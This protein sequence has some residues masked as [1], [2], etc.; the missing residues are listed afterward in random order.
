MSRAPSPSPSN[1][2]SAFE[3]GDLGMFEEPPGFRPPSP[4]PTFTHFDRPQGPPPARLELRLPPKHSLWGHWLW[5][6]GRV[7]ADYIDAH[8]ALVKGKAVCELGAGSAL[9]SLV[10]MANGAR[11]AAITDYPERVLLQN[12][13]YNV[14]ENFPGALEENRA[15]VVVGCWLP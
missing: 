10:A 8:P 12:I 6:A 3:E 4:E 11:I 14:R 15:A 13:E 2:S 7:G 5:N 1:A 9:P